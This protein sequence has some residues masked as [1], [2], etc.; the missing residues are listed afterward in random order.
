MVVDIDHSVSSGAYYCHIPEHELLPG[1]LDAL[2]DRMRALAAGMN[3]GAGE[4]QP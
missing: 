4:G 1:P 3:H 2:E